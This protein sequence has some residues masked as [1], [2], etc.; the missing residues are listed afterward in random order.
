[1][2]RERW[3]TG[4]RILVAAAVLALLL[5][6]TVRVHLFGVAGLLPARIN[7][8][9]G[10]PQ[11]GF[12]RPSAYPGVGFELRPDLDGYFKLAAFRT[13]S[14]GL[15]DREYAIAKPDGV[16]RV[17]VIGSSFALPAGVAIEDAFHSRLESRL[18]RER[19][20]QRFEFI[21]FAVGMHNPRQGLAMLEQRALA[22]H[23]DLVLFTSTQLSAPLLLPASSRPVAAA[24]PAPKRPVF[25]K[26]YP[27][28]Q[29]FLARLVEQ[30]LGFGPE[31]PELQVG[32]LEGWFMN[33]L[34]RVRPTPP[35]A[36][37][38]RAAD[39]RRPR[40]PAHSVLHAL[41]ALRDETGIPVL[42]VRL[43][44][45]PDGA[46][47]EEARV[48]AAVEALAAKLGLPHLDTRAAF[49]GR[50]PH[51]HWIYPLDPHPNAAAHGIFADVIAG[52]LASSGLLPPSTEGHRGSDP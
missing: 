24:S 2:I 34:E 41:A 38:P 43:A 45:D 47:D 1:L 17:A 46:S 51:D 20:P 6:L 18:T 4:A 29:S 26:S 39:A 5:E 49:A 48:D 35:H 36:R 27:I 37:P 19:A 44:F 40:P 52:F 33:A 9:H 7:S 11:T 42:V 10:L 8:V 16:F 13:S 3:R 25:Q 23:P 50:S 22:Y 14:Q 31:T 28:L 21:N 32:L 12:T 30:R 15:R